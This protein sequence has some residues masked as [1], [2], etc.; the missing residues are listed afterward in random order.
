MAAVPRSASSSNRTLPSLTRLRPAYVYAGIAAAV[1]L[2]TVTLVV[3]L[4][5]VVWLGSA[6]PQAVAIQKV[7]DQDKTLYVTFSH[8]LSAGTPLKQ[9]VHQ[10]VADMAEIDVTSCPGD[11]AQAY[12]QYRSATRQLAS[13][14][15]EEP[16]GTADALFQ[17]FLNGLG[18]E[19]DG[20]AGRLRRARDAA[21][22]QMIRAWGDVEATSAKYHIKA[23]AR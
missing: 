1:V 16:D 19:A 13:A 18:G 21:V 22:D 14:V 23:P 7:L 10:M 9:A 4:V 8:Q 17:G 11:F 2:L 3:A 20:G 12:V 6:N 15:D 5:V